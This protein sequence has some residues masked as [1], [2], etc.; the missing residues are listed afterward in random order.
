MWRKISPAIAPFDSSSPTRVVG[1]MGNSLSFTGSLCGGEEVSAGSANRI[2]LLADETSALDPIAAQ[3]DM[4]MAVEP[5]ISAEGVY[6]AQPEEYNPF[7]EIILPDVLRV[8]L[9]ALGGPLLIIAHASN[10]WMYKPGGAGIP[11]SIPHVPPSRE[12]EINGFAE[13]KRRD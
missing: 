8:R 6:F 11:W 7:A 5:V 10:Q 13:Q 1:V 12:F 9:T 2:T 4:A 3:P